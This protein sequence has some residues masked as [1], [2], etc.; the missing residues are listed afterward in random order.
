M[1]RLVTFVVLALIGVALVLA[2]YARRAV[3]PAPPVAVPSPPPGAL[4][5]VR[6]DLPAE[7][8]R[9][10]AWV[11]AWV[12]EPPGLTSDS[13]VALFF[14]GNGE[15]LETMRRAGLFEELRALGVLVLAAD[16]PGYGRSPGKPREEGVLATGDAAFRWAQSHHPERPLVLVGWSLG[17]AVAIETAAR[18][19]GETAGLVVMSSWTSLPEVARV[20]FPGFLVRWGVQE[21]YDSR[22]AAHR[23]AGRGVPALVIHGERDRIVPAEQGRRIAEALSGSA[24]APVRWVAVPGVGHNDLLAHRRVWEELERFL[25]GLPS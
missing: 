19:P 7:V 14:H 20:H 24:A 12:Q 5:E 4:E 22:G 16:Y 1:R 11:H 3:Y 23:L 9:G 6:L 25:A 17:A 2:S 13:P 10:G 8:G 21:R 18:H 15:N